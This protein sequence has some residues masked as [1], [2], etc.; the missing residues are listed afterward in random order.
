MR[1][2]IPLVLLAA[3]AFDFL[4]GESVTAEPPP[5]R[6]LTLLVSDHC[7]YAEPAQKEAKEFLKKNP[8]FHIVVINS[9]KEPERAKHAWNPRYVLACPSYV[10]LENGKP[11]AYWSGLARQKNLKAMKEYKYVAR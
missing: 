3:V 9:S 7:V 6:S 2:A 11:I 10:L 5:F 1:V 4:L 8:D